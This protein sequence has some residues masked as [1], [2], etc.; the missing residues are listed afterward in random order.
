MRSTGTGRTTRSRCCRVSLG[1][2]VR[3]TLRWRKA[4]PRPEVRGDIARIYWYMAETYGLRISNKQQRLFE[5]WSKGDDTHE[6]E[7]EKKK[8]IAQLEQ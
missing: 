4:E 5:A 2:T 1:S 3:V 8:R 6:W 7:I